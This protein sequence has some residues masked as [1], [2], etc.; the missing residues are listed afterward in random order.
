MVSA[1]KKKLA[2]Y[3]PPSSKK[4]RTVLLD[5]C[6]KDVEKDLTPIKDTWYS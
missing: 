2:G 3:K 5:E 4:A 6:H 1:I